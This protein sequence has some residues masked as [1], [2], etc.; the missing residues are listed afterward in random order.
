MYVDGVRQGW[1]VVSSP[2]CDIM[3]LTG[4]WDRGWLEGQARRVSCNTTVTECWLSKSCLH[5]PARVI[6]VRRFRMFRQEVTWMG[7]YTRGVASGVCWSRQ[8]GG[9]WL[10]GTVEHETGE[11]S[12]EEVAFIYPDMR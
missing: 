3:A 8:E 4:E 5:G 2:S 7:V 9:G 1:G 6:E 12:G 10:V 11:M